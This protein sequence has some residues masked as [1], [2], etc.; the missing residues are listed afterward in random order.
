LRD[1]RTSETHTRPRVL[2]RWVPPI[3]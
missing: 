1:G 3:E 2:S